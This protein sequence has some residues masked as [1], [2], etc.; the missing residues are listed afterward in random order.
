MKIEGLQAKTTLTF[1]V[2]LFKSKTT[3]YFVQEI[4][5]Y[6]YQ[7]N[8]E[9]KIENVCHAIFFTIALFCSKDIK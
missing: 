2:F 8:V 6:S 7:K 5:S 9:T 1:W 3:Q 4:C